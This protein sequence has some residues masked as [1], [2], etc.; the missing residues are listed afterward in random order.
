MENPISQASFLSA[1]QGRVFIKNSNLEFTYCNEAFARDLNL[2]PQNIVGTDDFRFFPDDLA[3]NNRTEDKHV[4]DTGRSLNHIKKHWSRDREV[5]VRVSKEPYFDQ[6]GKIAGVIGLLEDIPYEQSCWRGGSPEDM[7]K[8]GISSQSPFAVWEW[9]IDSDNFIVSDNVEKILGEKLVVNKGTDFHPANVVHEEDRERVITEIRRAVRDKR[10]FSMEL[11]IPLS[12]SVK[13]LYT[14]GGLVISNHDGKGRLYGIARDITN[15][16]DDSKAFNPY[17]NAYEVSSVPKLF[18]DKEGNLIHC[19]SAFMELWRINSSREFQGQLIHNFWIKNEVLDKGIQQALGEKHSWQGEMDALRADGSVFRTF[20][21]LNQLHDEAGRP[22]NIAVTVLDC[23]EKKELMDHNRNLASQF[24]SLLKTT[25]DG[26]WINDFQGNI[27]EV[28]DRICEMLEYDRDTLTA[29]KIDDVDIYEV[30][31]DVVARCHEILQQGSLLFK[32]RQK[33]RTG[34]ILN[35]EVSTIFWAEGKS[36]F[37][38]IRDTTE[39]EELMKDLIST[40][41]HL[42][43]MNTALKVVLS[44]KE[45]ESAD[46]FQSINRIVQKTVMPLLYQLKMENC[47]HHKEIIDQVIRNLQNL[48]KKPENKLVEKLSPREYQVARYIVQCLSSKEIADLMG[49]SLRT[50]ESY[51]LTIRKKLELNNTHRNLKCELESLLF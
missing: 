13:W 4:L 45:Q 35:V 1:L 39:Q 5:W 46:S 41:R 32:S 43:E 17:R 40:K 23:T 50:V 10:F 21:I 38:F 34:K 25:R 27:L 9:E 16:K 33:T 37:A 14:T 31:Q 26:F 15:W 48:Q 42:E 8:S 51:R 36:F 47:S 22:L 12:R 30:N 49:M 24:E 7:I 19:N 20:V 3:I 28:N 29:M 6:D 18:I 11:R 44:N 2:K